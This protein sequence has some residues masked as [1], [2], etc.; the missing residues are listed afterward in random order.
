MSH[1]LCAG[2]P[3]ESTIHSIARRPQIINLHP[4]APAGTL[5]PQNKMQAVFWGQGG[6]GGVTIMPNTACGQCPQR[7]YEL[8]F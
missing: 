3:N 8:Y 7:L 2:A 4:K 5:Q 1:P 6:N